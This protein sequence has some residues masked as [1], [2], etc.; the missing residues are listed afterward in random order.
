MAFFKFLEEFY[1]FLIYYYNVLQYSE[2]FAAAYQKGINYLV[3]T[4]NF[5]QN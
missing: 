4:Q 3:C 1:P 2:A 5:P